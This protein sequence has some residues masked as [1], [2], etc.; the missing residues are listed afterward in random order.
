MGYGTY[1]YP[2][3][4][5]IRYG[6]SYLTFNLIAQPLKS[7]PGG[8]AAFVYY[9]NLDDCRI[10]KHTNLG[11]AETVLTIPRSACSTGAFGPVNVVSC[12]SS[13]MTFQHYYDETCTQPWYQQSYTTVQADSCSPADVP[14]PNQV[15]CITDSGAV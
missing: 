1:S 3:N 8:G 13:A 12:D 15:L 5:C 11:R 14:I 7:I 4:E 10:S 6:G 9:D 2:K